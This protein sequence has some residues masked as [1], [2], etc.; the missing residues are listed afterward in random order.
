MW[1]DHVI[2]INICW[3][4]L[5]VYCRQSKSWRRLRGETCTNVSDKHKWLKELI[6]FTTRFWLVQFNPL[7]PLSLSLS[8]SLSLSLSLSQR[9]ASEM[10]GEIV[11]SLSPEDLKGLLPLKKEDLLV[12]VSWGCSKLFTCN[13]KFY[14]E[15]NLEGFN[16]ESPSLYINF[17]KLACSVQKLTLAVKI[18]TILLFLFTGCDVWLRHEGWE[19][20]RSC[21]ILC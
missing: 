9:K 7:Q 1:L 3:R 8:F 17:I 15:T 20:D 18:L 11:Q 14:T 2:N 21:E 16:Q 12:D 13:H 5:Y 6:R 10:A 4:C 19:S